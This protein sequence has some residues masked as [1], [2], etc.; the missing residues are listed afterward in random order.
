MSKRKIFRRMES[1]IASLMM[2]SALLFAA[3]RLAV[4]MPESFA[5][6]SPRLPIFTWLVGK[7]QDSETKGKLDFPLTL[8]NKQ[9]NNALMI[10]AFRPAIGNNWKSTLRILTEGRQVALAAVVKKD[11]WAVSKA[12]ELP[13]G[14][15]DCRCWDNRLV[16]G[17]VK[18]VDGDLDIALIQ[19]DR[20]DLP[21]V[22]WPAGTVVV[23]G[24]WVATT[25]SRESP[26]AI[27]V[28]SVPNRPVATERAILGVQLAPADVGAAV[29]SIIPGSGAEKAGV[30]IDDIIYEVNGKK[31]NSRREVLEAIASYRAGQRLELSVRRGEK[32][33][34]MTARLM[35]LTQAVLDPTEMEV[36]GSVSARSS[37]FPRVIQHD[38]VLNPNQ[39]GGPL[40]D[41]KGEVVGIN[42]ARA[43]RVSS[44]ALPS[45]VVQQ[46]LE[47]LYKEAKAK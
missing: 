21:A 35:D 38:T 5:A 40:V 15:F 41:L 23:A 14:D 42:I 27:G 37:G 45:D 4:R 17:R 11:G 24:A 13:E 22:I 18:A 32:Q 25:D 39:C 9:R 10:R 8:S 33:L 30:E 20:Q 44:Y 6:V 12:S 16:R 31:L 46:A 47:K 3:S 29:V 34:K 1:T 36:N 28:V 2:L 7:P 26:Q 43:S 19:F